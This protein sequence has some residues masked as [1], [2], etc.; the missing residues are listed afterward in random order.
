MEVACAECDKLFQLRGGTSGY[1]TS[2]C[3]KCY[4]KYKKEQRRKK[5]GKKMY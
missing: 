4:L 5:N 3:G 2:L 1:T